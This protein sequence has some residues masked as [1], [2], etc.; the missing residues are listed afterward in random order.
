MVAGV[1]LVAEQKSTPI[2]SPPTLRQ[3]NSALISSLDN[4][5]EAY[6]P[7]RGYPQPG[8]RGDVGQRR[9]MRR[10][11]SDRSSGILRRLFAGGGLP[12]GRAR[13]VCD[14]YTARWV[15]QAKVMLRSSIRGCQ[16]T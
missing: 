12:A 11:H 8:H 3:E 7:A 14:E 10:K 4:V 2:G 13:V 15:I 5:I 16:S 6:L 1:T 9:G